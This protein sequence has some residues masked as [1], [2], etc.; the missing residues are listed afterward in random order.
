M[1]TAPQYTSQGSCEGAGYK[2]VYAYR[3][4]DYDDDEDQI[5]KKC[6]VPLE[7]PECRVAPYSRSNHL[8]NGKGITP[9]TYRWKLPNYPSKKEQRCFLRIRYGKTELGLKLNLPALTFKISQLTESL[10]I[11]MLSIRQV[12]ALYLKFLEIGSA[13]QPL[14]RWDLCICRDSGI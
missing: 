2:W 7:K 5:K 12:Y 10:S 9:L 4:D 13:R 1:E 8:G 14:E 11:L 6:V 3:S